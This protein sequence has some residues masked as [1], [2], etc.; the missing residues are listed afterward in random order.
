MGIAPAQLIP[1]PLGALQKM[2]IDYFNLDD[3]PNE[4]LESISEK[5]FTYTV[6]LLEVVHDMPG[7]DTVRLLGIVRDFRAANSDWLRL[8]CAHLLLGSRLVPEL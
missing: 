6:A 2:A 8:V 1:S 5:L 7:L 4:T 3:V